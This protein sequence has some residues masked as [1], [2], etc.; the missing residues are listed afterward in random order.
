MGAID[1]GSGVV[2]VA[3]GARLWAVRVLDNRGSGFLSW[4][5]CG[6]NW[7]AENA[8]TVE[9]ANMSLGFSGTSV[10]LND[11]IDAAVA[12]GIVFAVAAGNSNAD[13]GNNSPANH[14]AVLTVSALADS[15]DLPG[16]GGPATSYG[17]DDTLASFSNYGSVVDLAAP[18][19]D[20][21]S[22]Y[23]GSAYTRMS[24]TSMASPHVAGAAALYLAT[25]PKPVDAGGA[26]AVRTAIV[27]AAF[28]QAGPDGFTGDR[29]ASAEPLLNAGAF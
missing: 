10:A 13:A 16:G 26:L 3:P 24:G 28:P 14:P 1:N 6:V 29:D 17:P 7:V 22:T 4:V 2:G 19:V 9:V 21:L 25:R 20:I 5:L 23:K 12:R 8:G 27:V 11:A 18:G 15:N